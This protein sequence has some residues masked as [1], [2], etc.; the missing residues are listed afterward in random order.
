MNIHGSLLSPIKFK[1]PEERKYKRHIENRARPI[2]AFV[3]WLGGL[4]PLI[5]LLSD[6][7]NHPEQF[8]HLV[9]VRSIYLVFWGLM[10]FLTISRWRFFS[11]RQSLLIYVSVGIFYI[12][13]LNVIMLERHMQVVPSALFFLFGIVICQLGSKLSL[14]AGVACSAIPIVT[15]AYFD[16]FGDVERT[17]ILMLIIWS[18]ATW[19]SSIILEKVNRRLFLYEQDINLANKEKQQLLEREFESNRFKR[20]F[21]ANMSHEIRTPLTA[22]MGYADSYFQDNQSRE[23]KEGIVKTIYHNGEHLLTLVNDILDLSKIEAG[24]FE[25]DS[26]QCELFE[27]LKDVETMQTV[28][29]GGKGLNLQLHYHF[30]L[31]THIQTDPTRLKQVLINLCT[32]AI[33][34]TDKGSVDVDICYQAEYDE[35]EFTVRDTG[36][37]MSEEMQQALFKPYSQASTTFKRNSGGT[38]LGLFISKQLVEK[39]GGNFDVHSKVDEGSSFHFQIKAQADETN[40]VM[41]M[42]EIAVNPKN[43]QKRAIQLQGKVLLAEDHTDNRQLILMHLQQLGLEVDQVCN[44]A[45]AVEHAIV[46]EYDLILMDIQMPVMSGEQATSIIR[47]TDSDTPIIALT[48]NAMT[49]EVNHYL[50]NGFNA[51]ISKPLN[52]AEFH[53]V[54]GSFCTENNDQADIEKTETTTQVPQFSLN[55]QAYQRLVKEYVETLPCEV[56]MLKHAKSTHNWEKLQKV[57]HNLKGAAGNFGFADISKHA[58]R[59]ETILKTGD[60]AELDSIFDDLHFELNQVLYQHD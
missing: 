29:A 25:I 5:F 39:M 30:P 58:E 33:K 34:F 42:P 51:H 12:I 16:R 15:L 59:L 19:L 9:Q 10:T 46:N 36:I 53:K 31:P 44:G 54:I 32:N 49:N 8:D 43:Q 3:Y 14:L 41:C 60:L 18:V 28:I 17:V 27:L 48:A 2:V 6:Y 1:E 45:E 21:L 55:S 4:L 40:L 50:T 38:G 24:K 52:M 23:T 57:A 37:G 7:F 22:I 56:E 20:E 26:K 35:L 11:L 13:F 47:Q